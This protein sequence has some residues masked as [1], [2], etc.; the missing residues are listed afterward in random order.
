VTVRSRL[1]FAT[2]V[3]VVFVLGGLS[4]VV[5]D[6]LWL[7]ERGRAALGPGGLGLGPGPGRRGGGPGP[8]AIEG[9]IARLDRQLELTGAQRDQLRDILRRWNDRATELQRDARREF[10]EAQA[11]LRA[12]IEAILSADQVTRFRSLRG[13]AG[14][15]RRGR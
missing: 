4:G 3:L 14:P 2:F 9:Q 13:D 6:R 11:A 15:G 10:V 12:D 7:I 8:V 1:W 5:L